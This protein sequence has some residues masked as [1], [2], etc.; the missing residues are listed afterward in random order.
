MI[1]HPIVKNDT[2]GTYTYR[3]VPGSLNE[4]VLWNRL[5]VDIDGQSG[6]MPIVIDTLSDWLTMKDD[7]ME[8]IRTWI[9]NGAPDMFGN[10]SNIPNQKPYCIGA[11]GFF[12]NQTTFPFETTAKGSIEIPQGTGGNIDLWFSIHDDSTNAG[13]LGVKEIKYCLSRD[14][15][16]IALLTDNLTYQANGITYEDFFGNL[17]TYNYK[18]SVDIDNL[19]GGFDGRLF[20]R[21]YVKDPQHDAT[22]IPTYGSADHIKLYFSLVKPQ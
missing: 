11:L 19:G 4:S 5:T 1:Y 13:A 18:V 12:S 21:V 3:V 16:N 9:L 10:S 22:E 17:V 6:V 8:N 2:L 20:F 7:Y 14:N 15:F